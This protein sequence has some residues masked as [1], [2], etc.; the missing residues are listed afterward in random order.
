V[1]AGDFQQIPVVVPNGSRD[2]TVSSC[3]K[4]ATAW[5]HVTEYTLTVPMRAA[6]DAD[7]AAFLEAVARGTLPRC[8][9]LGH[10][11]TA[12]ANSAAAAQGGLHHVFLPTNIAG[13]CN[14]FT[15]ADTF[16]DFI[17]APDLLANPNH[18]GTAVQSSVTAGHND[19]VE[20]HNDYFLARLT[21]QVT[22]VHATE[23][24]TGNAD[25]DNHQLLMTDDFMV[26][27]TRASSL[28]GLPTN[29]PPFATPSHSSSALALPS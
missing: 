11:L 9:P 16:R 22:V 2:Q 7:Y 26:R 6:A 4:A 1:F 13:R 20:A 29:V 28:P 18:A 21:G 3:A 12:E 19:I 24:L 8:D 15:D 5:A 27:P 25:E 10:L 23:R 14:I 17:H